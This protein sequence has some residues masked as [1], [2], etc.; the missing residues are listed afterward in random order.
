M[1]YGNNDTV[2]AA[3]MCDKMFKTIDAELVFKSEGLF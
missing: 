2:Y 1:I 3:E